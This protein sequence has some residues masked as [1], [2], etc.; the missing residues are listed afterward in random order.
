MTQP[1]AYDCKEAF[2]RL[3]DFLDR[4]LSPQEVALVEDHLAVCDICAKEYRFESDLL[5]HLKQRIRSA[6]APSELLSRVMSVL[7]SMRT[8]S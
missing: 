8:D 6:K 1:T 2:S 4:E 3:G 7:N 5:V